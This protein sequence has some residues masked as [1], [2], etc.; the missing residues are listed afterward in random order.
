MASYTV[1]RQAGPHVEEKTF[2]TAKEVVSFLKVFLKAESEAKAKARKDEEV[3]E[4]KKEKKE[5]EEVKKA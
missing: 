5:P 2:S 1:K 4:K 3:E